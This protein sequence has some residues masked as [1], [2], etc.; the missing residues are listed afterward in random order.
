MHASHKRVALRASASVALIVIGVVFA[1]VF[2][3]PSHP[4]LDTGGGS[5]TVGPI[6]SRTAFVNAITIPKEMRLSCVEVLLATRGE[7]SNTTNDEIRVFDGAGH[8]LQAEPLPPGSVADN[9]YV[10]VD[11]SQ[12]I[13]VQAHGTVFIALSS[14]DGT[15]VDSIT[16]WTTPSSSVGRLYALSATELGGG[17]PDVRALTAHPRPGSISLRVLGLGRRGLIAENLLRLFGLLACVVPAGGVWWAATL[18]RWCASTEAALRVESWRQGASIAWFYLAVALV[19]GVA[20]IAI[21][22]PFQAPDEPAHYFRA[23]SV[24]SFEMIG[25]QGAVVTVPENVATLPDRL[26]TN[27]GG[28]WPANQYSVRRAG[29]AL[30]ERIS[31]TNR[32]QVTSAAASAPIGYVPQAIGIEIARVLGHS[33]LLGFYLGRLLNLIATVV[34]VFL[35]IRVVPFG[36]PFFALVGLLPMF[37]FE[38]ASLS[39]DG[40]ALSGCLLFLALV[41]RST[42][43]GT[44]PARELIVTSCVAVILLNAKPGYAV[45]VLLLFMLTPRQLGGVRRYAVWIGATIAAAF[46]VGAGAA[47]VAPEAPAGY[48][49]WMGLG[50]VDPGRQ[51]AFVVRNPFE[52]ARV[53]YDTFDQQ[54]LGLD[55]T[56]LGLGQMAYGVLGWL[57]VYLPT[58][59]MWAMGLAGVLFLGSREEVPTTPWQRFVLGAT[60]AIL[61][62]AVSIGLYTGWTPVA[63]PVINGL[64][65]RYFIPVIPL[66]LFAVYGLRPT[67]ERTLLTILAVAVGIAAA[68]TVATLLRFYF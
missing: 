65:G 35:A 68:T 39:P 44:I 27:V 45:L 14:A 56:R 4:V 51:L 16:A 32:A 1:L 64:Q 33:P 34:L 66:G 53:L 15:S 37:V 13:R 30:W 20:L 48:Y 12:P 47:L 7:P 59:G 49:A 5:G 58:V 52:F 57:S 24:A 42:T 41:L 31:K 61:V 60:G 29:G 2:R 46:S 40:L 36:R 11:L 67:R 9:S 50:A 26:G 10:R 3:M 62:S 17:S 25:R 63:A 28:D 38:A 8:L 6:T 22:P 55:H 43:R 21:T 23:W 18:K 54:A 19:W